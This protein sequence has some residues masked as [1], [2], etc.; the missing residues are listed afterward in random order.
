MC[1]AERA[2]DDDYDAVK[3]KRD[4]GEERA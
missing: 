4:T 3:I 1:G 2:L